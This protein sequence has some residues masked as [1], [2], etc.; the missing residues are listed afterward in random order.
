V[1]EGRWALPGLASD[2]RKGNGLLVVAP[3]WR[4]ISAGES[5]AAGRICAKLTH[6]EKRS[7][8]ISVACPSAPFLSIGI[9]VRLALRRRRL[10]RPD[11]ARRLAPVSARSTRTL[12]HLDA[13]LGLG[14]KP[15]LD[16]LVAHVLEL[17]DDLVLAPLDEHPPASMPASSAKE[18]EPS[19]LTMSR[20]PRRRGCGSARRRLISDKNP[21]RALAAFAEPMTRSPPGRKRPGPRRAAPGHHQ[22]PGV[23]Y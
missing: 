23:P 16:L 3:A 10:Q 21:L 13:R 20:A 5:P 7:R 22:W 6:S 19:W 11:N 15:R 8:P 2:H 4:R 18:R 1:G 14:I 17:V 9:L 12:P